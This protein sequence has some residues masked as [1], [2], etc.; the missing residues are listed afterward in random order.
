MSG[1][2][3]DCVGHWDLGKD[4]SYIGI[5]YRILI[6]LIIIARIVSGALASIDG[7]III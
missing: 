1:Y 3:F 4:K 5:S 7:K 6:L 2:L